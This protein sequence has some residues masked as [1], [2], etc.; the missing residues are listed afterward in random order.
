MRVGYEL[1]TR[2]GRVDRGYT[3]HDIFTLDPLRVREGEAYAMGKS[4]LERANHWRGVVMVEV[5]TV[6]LKVMVLGVKDQAVFIFYIILL[7]LDVA[8]IVVRKNHLSQV[9]SCRA[10]QGESVSLCP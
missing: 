6:A 1:G 4:T 7:S 9:A 10:P 3:A 2:E 8:F 5:S